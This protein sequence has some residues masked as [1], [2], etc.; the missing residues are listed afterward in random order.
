[1]AWG[2]A[3]PELTGQIQS[4][5]RMVFHAVGDTGNT[6]SLEP[7]EQ[8]SSKMETDFNEHHE[9][10]KPQFFL[11]LGDVIY[12]FGEEKYYYDQ[13]YEPYR[14]Y[15]APIIAIAG[16]H[17]GMVAPDSA[18]TS[19]GAFWKNFC[20]KEPAFTAEAGGL[21]RTAMTQPGVYYTLDAGLA[22]ILCLYS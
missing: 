17:D 21:D 2:K 18:A 13:F 7:Q 20:A 1:D 22:R 15:P 14:N 4:A 5:G 19:L 3:N 8:V 11:H 6:R 12:S 16:N 9:Y 10:E